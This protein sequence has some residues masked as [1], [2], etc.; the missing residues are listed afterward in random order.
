LYDVVGIQGKY[1]CALPKRT[2]E[3]FITLATPLPMTYFSVDDKTVSEQVFAGTITRLA[4]SSAEAVLAQPMPLHSNLKLHLEAVACGGLSEAYAKI[5]AFTG[6]DASASSAHVCLGFTSL[7]E[8][9]QGFLDQQRTSAYQE[10]QASS[11]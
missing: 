10:A 8:D 5:V 1:A 4:A 2:P 3:T 11:V 7:P 6:D 9:V